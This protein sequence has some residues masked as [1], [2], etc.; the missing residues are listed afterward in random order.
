MNWFTIVMMWSSILV[1]WILAVVT[2][3]ELIGGKKYLEWLRIVLFLG[4]GIVFGVRVFEYFTLGLGFLLVLGLG[5]RAV[6]FLLRRVTFVVEVLIELFCFIW[7]TVVVLWWGLGEV[8]M[9]LLFVSV[10]FMYGLVVGT[11][12]NV[13]YNIIAK[14][15]NN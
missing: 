6:H 2:A 12:L 7:A 13:K 1:G 15:I 5:L 14:D 4:A 8:E 3:E 10:V 9:G 11:L